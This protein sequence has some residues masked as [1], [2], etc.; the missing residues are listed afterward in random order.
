ML[1][2]LYSLRLGY[3][4]LCVYK[5]LLLLLIRYGPCPSTTCRVL[6]VGGNMAS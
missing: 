3:F 6:C 1:Q 5:H 2:I 4:R